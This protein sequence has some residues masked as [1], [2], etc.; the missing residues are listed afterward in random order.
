MISFK[1]KRKKNKAWFVMMHLC[2]P[3]LA[4]PLLYLAFRIGWLRY[5]FFLFWIYPFIF[6]IASFFRGAN[7]I[8]INEISIDPEN[9]QMYFSCFQFWN[10]NK[11]H[12]RRFDEIKIDIVTYKR[13]SFSKV[14]RIYFFKSQ[15]GDF[16]LSREKDLFSRASMIQI[17]ELLSNLTTPV[18]R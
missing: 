12:Q 14:C 18:K 8:Y 10:G 15:P 7:N 5:S 6:S 1:S 17:A 13:F 2:L 3:L 11:E 16:Y 9:R 4:G